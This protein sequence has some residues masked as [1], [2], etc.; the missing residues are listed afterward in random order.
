MFLKIKRLSKFEAFENLTCLPI[1]RLPPMF[2]Q[3]N[4]YFHLCSYQCVQLVTVYFYS[5]EHL[6]NN[7]VGFSLF[8]T[9]HVDV[10]MQ[11]G[12]CNDSEFKQA[13]CMVS[14]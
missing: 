2:M 9:P 11:K 7:W 8:Y 4:I 5:A 6:K 3:G 13:H 1:S 10:G 12:D 14:S